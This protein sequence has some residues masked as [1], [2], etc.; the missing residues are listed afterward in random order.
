MGSIAVIGAAGFVG[1]R[2]IES[3]ILNGFK[4]FY[5]VLRSHRSLGRLSRF[6][7]A[8]NIKIA[9]AENEAALL[10]AIRDC[11]IVVNLIS[12]NPAGIIKSTKAIYNSCVTTGVKRFIHL[13][14]AAVYGRVESPEIPD[15]S[16]PIKNHWMPYASAKAS[17]ELFL[18]SVL[19]SSP[20][21]ITI[22][23]PGIV[24]GPRSRWSINAALDLINHAAYLV[25]DG[26]GVCNTIYVDNLISCILT[27]SNHRTSASGFFNVSDDEF[28]TW[29]DFYGSLAR[30]LSYDMS[31]IP[32]VPADRFRP[33]LKGRLDDIM[34]SSIYNKLKTH[35]P[36]ET[37]ALI[38]HWLMNR[39][40]KDA[41]DMETKKNRR[42]IDVT[43][44]MWNLQTT[45]FKLS[46]SKFAKHFNYRPHF[47][48]AHGSEMTMHWLSFLGI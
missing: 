23:R 30:Y 42:H 27:C 37:R 26:S 38:K 48:F 47:S 34:L 16:P 46:N 29:R 45:K 11:S 4:D 24:W 7:S 15:D 25:G 43:R 40:V 14:S 36:V 1:S 19:T 17:A 13:S 10:P 28:V 9:D 41:V 8:A 5:S 6:G 33:S 21:E 31:N 3:F 20:P 39:L 18:R 44:E 12:G 35:I 32:S 22:L 2:L